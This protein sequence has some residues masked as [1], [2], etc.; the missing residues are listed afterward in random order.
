MSEWIPDEEW[1]TIVEHVPIVSVDL[2]VECPDGIVLG[3]RSNEPAKGEWFVPGGRVQKG[4]S[5]EES[6]HRV[7]EEELGVNIEIREKLGVFE[8]F[9]DTSEVGC[10]K[11]YIA[12]GFSVW[13]DETTFD[14]DNQHDG[15]A[16]FEGVPTDL[17][18]Y[19]QTYLEVAGVR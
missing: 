19:V 12:H 14:S 7:A 5:L 17:H 13:T 18:P 6:V 15:I 10:E 3:K 1:T 16:V 8:H 9:Y 4:E 2:V 11:H